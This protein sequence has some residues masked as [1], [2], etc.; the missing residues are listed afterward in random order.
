MNPVVYKMAIILELLSTSQNL[1]MEGGLFVLSFL[2][3]LFVSNNNE[4][5]T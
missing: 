2:R 1:K 5:R 4:Y 3:I